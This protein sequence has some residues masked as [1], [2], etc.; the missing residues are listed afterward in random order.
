VSVANVRWY[1]SAAE[2]SSAFCCTT[3]IALS[4]ELGNVNWC[5]DYG[6]PVVDLSTGQLRYCDGHSCPPG[7][8]CYRKP[9]DS[10]PARCCRQSSCCLRYYP[11]I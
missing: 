2:A 7:S 11:S 9:S 10:L 4:A 6:I 5:G 3:D 1:K 8:H